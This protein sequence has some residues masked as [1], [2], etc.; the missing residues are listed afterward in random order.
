MNYGWELIACHARIPGFGVPE[1]LLRACQ[2]PQARQTKIMGVWE[3]NR[4]VILFGELVLPSPDPDNLIIYCPRDFDFD[5]EAV[6]FCGGKHWWLGLAS[7]VDLCCQLQSGLRTDSIHHS[8]NPSVCLS[9][10]RIFIAFCQMHS[11]KPP[12]LFP[13]RQ[14]RGGLF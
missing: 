7:S 4:Q 5:F 13:R 12:C 3:K 11:L 6:L 10:H 14:I 1:F 9:F 2:A 8:F